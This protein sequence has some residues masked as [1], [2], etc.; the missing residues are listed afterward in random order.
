MGGF[1]NYLALSV[2]TCCGR[3]HGNPIGDEG[4]V[5]IVDALLGMACPAANQAKAEAANEPNKDS[6]TAPDAA[7]TH[8]DRQPSEQA[9]DDKHEPCGDVQAELTAEEAPA[10][11]A[12]EESSTGTATE[13][14]SPVAATEN[15]LAEIT[16]EEPSAEQ[17]TEEA[18]AN[19]A[20]DDALANTASEEAPAETA[21]EEAPAETATE[22]AQAEPATTEAPTEST[23]E[24]VPGETAKEEAQGETATEE[25]QA[26]AASGEAPEET[27]TQEP[28]ATEEAPA[29]EATRE[30]QAETA[31]ENVASCAAAAAVPPIQILDLGD[32]NLTDKCATSLSQLLTQT[33]TLSELNLS[34][35]CFSAPG[36][37]DI[38]DA[39][40]KNTSL[41][42]LSLDYCGV[43]C[44]KLDRQFF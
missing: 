20:T 31:T 30:S 18:Q 5:T 24:E 41:T 12:A 37:A 27:A 38:G 17:A 8:V 39:I 3:L 16:T 10:Q 42:S 15:P 36:L 22:E 29:E 43:R 28:T 34:G 9:A 32:C 7:N 19:T 11:P 40:G 33:K 14:L 26:E 35:N 6:P 1:P 21:E 13:E 4:V 23:A 2:C 44:S 25:A